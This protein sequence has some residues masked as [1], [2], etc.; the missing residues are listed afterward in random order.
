MALTVGRRKAVIIVVS[1]VL[2][3]ALIVG[4]VLG[5]RGCECSADETTTN[6]QTTA[7][8][9]STTTIATTT[10]EMPTTTTKS[11]VAHKRKTTTTGTPTTVTTT[12][13]PFTG[14]YTGDY[15]FDGFEPRGSIHFVVASNGSIAGSGNLGGTPFV[16]TGTAGSG[17]ALTMSGTVVD[18]EATYIITFVGNF[19]SGGGSAAGDCT[20]SNDGGT[21]NGTW[22]ATNDAGA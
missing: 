10:T 15:S 17:G 8:T 12:A 9:P 3:A 22:S 20:L 18:V 2:G 21:V 13:N 14:A 5:L 1:L 11:V 16:L 7:G 6:I 19:S 4:L